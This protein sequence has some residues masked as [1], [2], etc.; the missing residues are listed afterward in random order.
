V[1]DYGATE[2]RPEH[3]LLGGLREPLLPDSSRDS[4]QSKLH[5]SAVELENL[6]MAIERVTVRGNP[7]P[8]EHGDIPLS[9]DACRIVEE[10]QRLAENFHHSFLRPCHLMLAILTGGG[11]LSAAVSAAGITAS[12]VER[13]LR[14]V[15]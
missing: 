11:D 12:T 10:A 3:L 2:I 5:L 14:E 6:R 8:R 13:A 1:A 4:L 9:G 7:R 15:S